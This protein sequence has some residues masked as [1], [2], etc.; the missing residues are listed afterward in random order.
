MSGMTTPTVSRPLVLGGTG[1]TGRRITERLVASG[2]RPVVATRH[3]DGPDERRFDWEDRSTWAA[4]LS[5]VDAVYLCYAPDLAVPSAADTVAAVAELAVRSGA[6]RLVLLSGRG[7]PEAQRAEEAVR[8]IAEEWAVVRAGWF[9]QNFSESFF[10]DGV[11]AGE[12]A[13]PVGDVREPFADAD[14]DDVAEVAV[15]AL[16]DDRQLGRVHEVTGPEALSVAEAVDVIAEA[17]GRPIR[18]RSTPADEY[19]A[20]MRAEGVPDDVVQLTGYLFDTV[21]DGRNSAVSDGVGRAL[22]RPAR[23]FGDYARRTAATGIWDVPAAA[24]SS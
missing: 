12:L 23:S 11:L 4:A 14:A 10:L 5:G 2:V 9:A 8:D 18:F 21:L 16:V 6:H 22:G 15:A 19:A 24:S 1:K 3:A 20:A 17:C 13:L 7:E